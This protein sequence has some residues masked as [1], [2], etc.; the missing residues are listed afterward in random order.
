[1]A[2]RL[3]E[4]AMLWTTLIQR[5]LP[6]VALPGQAMQAQANLAPLAEPLPPLDSGDDM[7]G[8]IPPWAIGLGLLALGFGVFQFGKRKAT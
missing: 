2:K 8:D 3:T 4:S 5:T 1:M 6:N 7:M